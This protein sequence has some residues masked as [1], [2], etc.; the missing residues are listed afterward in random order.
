MR[1]RIN[2]TGRKKIPREYISIVPQAEGGFICDLDLEPL[3]L[4]A[5][6]L[7]VVEAHR[8]SITERFDFGT[9][10]QPGPAGSTFLRQLK[11]EDATFRVKVVDPDNGRLLARADRLQPNEN[12]ESGRKELLTVKV[13][14]LGPEPWKVEIDAAGEP[15]LIL[16]EEIPA[17]GTRITSDPSFQAL[18]LPAAFRQ[19]LHLLW[20]AREQ[21]EQD[22]D[23][24]ASRWIEFSQKLTRQDRPDWE[25]SDEVMEWIDKACRAFADAHPFITAFKGAGNGDTQT[26]E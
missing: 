25:E 4:P 3:E 12:N 20:A 5:H 10:S 23:T 11:I 18:V 22:G 13:K 2:S 14:D 6:G 21:T 7:L 9:V 15:V 24:P 8:Q 19:V 16:N 26:F 1:R 17:A